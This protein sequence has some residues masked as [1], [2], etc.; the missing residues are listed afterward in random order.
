MSSDGACKFSDLFGVFYC[1][2]K[3]LVLVAE[4]NCEAVG[5]I[6]CYDTRQHWR[7]L[8]QV[9]KLI[10]FKTGSYKDASKQTLAVLVI[11]CAGFVSRQCHLTKPRNDS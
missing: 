3:K 4:V 8:L 1:M 10:S 9:R 5:H 11:F 7:S 6:E 2:D